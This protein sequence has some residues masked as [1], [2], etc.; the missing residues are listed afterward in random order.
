VARTIADLF[1]RVGTDPT[2]DWTDATVLLTHPQQRATIRPYDRGHGLGQ[3]VYLA[4]TLWT[5]SHRSEAKAVT[6]AVQDLETDL[7][8]RIDVE[9]VDESRWEACATQVVDLEGGGVSLVPWTVRG[10]RARPALAPRTTSSRTR[11]G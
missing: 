10:L 8:V 5:A 2:L 11:R 7:W 4:R 9:K 1:G 6:R 3:A